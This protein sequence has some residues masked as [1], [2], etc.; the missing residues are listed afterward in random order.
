MR[1]PCPHTHVDAGAGATDRLLRDDSNDEIRSGDDT[2]SDE[3]GLQVPDIASGA[4]GAALWASSDED[5]NLSD[6]AAQDNGADNGG[7]H[8]GDEWVFD[9]GGTVIGD[10]AAGARAAESNQKRDELVERERRELD[11]RQSFS[12]SVLRDRGRHI[13]AILAAETPTSSRAT[14]LSESARKLR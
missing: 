10:V 7:G 6:D 12:I 8:H 1:R 4:G 2:D 11:D 9:D 13:S 3:K 5:G 14:V